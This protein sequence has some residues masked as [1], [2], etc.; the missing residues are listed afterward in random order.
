MPLVIRF[1][2]FV[3]KRKK[4]KNQEAVAHDCRKN[5]QGSSKSMEVNVAVELFSDA[6]SCGVAY[7]TY[8][9]DDDS[10]TESHLKH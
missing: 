3:L 1:V 10:A 8:L 5:H 4:E 7:T 9:G 2:G 6:L